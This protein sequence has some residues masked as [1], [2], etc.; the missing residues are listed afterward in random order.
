MRDVVQDVEVVELRVPA[1]L[2][3]KMSFGAV[4]RVD[5]VL[6][7]I[8]SQSGRTGLGEVAC[9]NG[10]VFS[11]EWRGSIAALIR[12][13]LAP[14][15]RELPVSS[16]NRAL[17]RMDAQ[18][19]GNPF[20]KAAVEMALWDLAAQEKDCSV[21]ELLGGS[22]RDRIPASVGLY[23]QDTEEEVAICSKAHQEGRYFF[24]A[25]VGVIPVQE[26][27]K[28]VSRLREVV[29]KEPV[30]GV[31]AN[32]GWTAAESL[33]FVR[34]TADLRL[35][36]IEQPLQRW[37]LQGMRD[38]ALLGAAP[39]MADESIF[40]AT[41]AFQVG[42]ARAARIASIKI[43][44]AGGISRALSVA[45]VLAAAGIEVFLGSMAE[46]GVGAAAGLQLASI[47]P[48]IFGCELLPPY[49]RDIIA[50]PLKVVKGDL[51]VPQG[52]GLGVRLD[53]SVVKEYA[54]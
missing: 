39:I 11:E 18:A 10:P 34:D 4:D 14:A 25:K 19:K 12:E 2:T 43:T 28:R 53:D 24:K 5:H 26:D 30:F 44:K 37:D 1:R 49:E 48:S 21:A 13:Y 50:E 54:I 29:G 20:A 9:E 6:V 17:N 22:L 27:I 23:T 33:R 31:D 41:D 40:S 47:L 42:V 32:Q 36:F 52:V 35:S 8:R 3:I 7:I 51:L 38:L 15:I 45:N 16:I 46:L